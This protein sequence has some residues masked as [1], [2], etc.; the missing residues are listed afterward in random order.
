MSAL[1]IRKKRQP[2]QV[3]HS[4]AHTSRIRTNHS[5]IAVQRVTSIIPRGK[6]LVYDI[7]VKKYHNFFANGQLVHNC[8]IT[9]GVYFDSYNVLPGVDQVVPVDVYVPGCPPRPEELID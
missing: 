1:P 7:E 5:G 4:S 2:L 9:G 6:E 8:S 3:V